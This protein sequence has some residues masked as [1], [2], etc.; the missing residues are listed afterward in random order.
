MAWTSRLEVRGAGKWSRKQD[1]G[2]RTEQNI[3][4]A[5]VFHTYTS[6]NSHLL[7]V[8]AHLPI[9]TDKNALKRYPQP[10][11]RTLRE[12]ITI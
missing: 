10:K 4:L 2:S 6:E 5:H 9:S 3:A 1:L 7:P 11:I 8:A 12:Q